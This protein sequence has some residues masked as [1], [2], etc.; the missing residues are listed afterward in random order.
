MPETSIII[1]TFNEEKHIGNLLQRIK[2]QNYRDHEIILVDSGSTDR[3][4]KIAEGLC[5]NIL[6]IDSKDFTFGYSL[7]I[8][9]RNSKGKYLVLISAHTLPTNR[10]WLSHLLMPFQNEKTAMVYGK[11]ISAQE[12][13]FSEKRDFERLFGNTPK[14]L[15]GAS[16]YANNANSAV[17]KELWEKHPFDEYLFGLEDIE[18]AKY[19]T[20]SGFSINYEPKAAVYHI[21]DEKWPQ[22]FNRYRREAIAA[23]KIGLTHPPQAEP[24]F[25]WFGKNTVQ[26]LAAALHAFSLAKFKKICL[27]RYYQW[28]GTKQGWYYDKDIDLNQK[29]YAL[30]YPAANQA[31]VI[32]AQRRARFQEIT[33][34][35]VKPGDVLIQVAYVGVCRTDLEVYEGA[36]A[37]Y[38]QG[39]AK[40]PI[41]PGHE[42]SGTIV[43][44][45]ANIGKEWQ[46]GDRVVGECILSCGSCSFCQKGIQTACPKRRE[47]GVMNYDGAYSQFIVFPGRY[48]HKIPKGMNLKTACLT[49]PL[50]VV[51]R[52]LRRI[53]NRI[54]P[55]DNI[56]VTGA[57]PIGNLCAQTLLNSGYKITVFDKNKE[58]LDLLKDTIKTSQKLNG[59]NKF[60]VIIEATGAADVLKRILEESRAD[61][62]LLLLGFPYGNINYNFE[63]LVGQEKV[64]IGSV[65]G[66]REDFKEAL[67]LLPKLNTYPFTQ[68][69][70]PLKE[71]SKAWKLQRT[72]KYLKIILKP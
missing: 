10:Q 5:D 34:P 37:Y 16:Y 23:R 20:K 12:T 42:F 58:R 67:K 57:G 14:K 60:D 30:Y 24:N 13:K 55:D 39:I 29:K 65:G 49:E 53:S 7:N 19:A 25:F 27:F 1:R 11:Q 6:Q 48:L 66:A 9:C 68:Q 36:L 70:L 31:A 15:N 69:V 2:E 64:I 38:Q 22:V 43:R 35:E 26:D 63:N 61:A 44:L 3:T 54:K 17:K 71:F 33:L 56:A 62:T 50:A 32:S 52:A 40:Y 45:G 28:Q 41:I 8:G 47:V 51:L 18:W 21:H 4:L 59:L 72:L 46:I